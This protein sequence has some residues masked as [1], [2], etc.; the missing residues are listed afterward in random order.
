MESKKPLVVN[1]DTLVPIGFIAVILLGAVR[2]E[3]IGWLTDQVTVRAA[4]NSIELKAQEKEID[5]VKDK[6]LEA[7]N[8]IN[9]RLA[10]LKG[11]K[12]GEEKKGRS[13]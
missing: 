7:V 1:K 5:E 3:K 6:F 11:V 2:V 8:D 9:L 10:E 4:E 12:N 13:N